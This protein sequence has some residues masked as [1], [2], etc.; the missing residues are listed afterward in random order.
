M[1]TF[2]VV[3]TVVTEDDVE[4]EVVSNDIRDYVSGGFDGFELDDLP[5]YGMEVTSIEVTKT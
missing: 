5:Q 2:S 1:S 3:M 4:A